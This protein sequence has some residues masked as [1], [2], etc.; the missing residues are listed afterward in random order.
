MIAREGMVPLLAAILVA[1]LVM[2]F[3]GTVPSL[4]FW[5]LAV[6][7]L[8][9]FMDPERDIPSRPMAVLSPADGKIVT[10]SRG[11]HDPYLLR[12]SIFVSV[13]MS[14][15]GV[16]TMRSPIEGKVLEP[17]NFPDDASKPISKLAREFATPSLKVL[18][19]GSMPVFQ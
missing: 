14:P 19:V 1:V 8:V 7:V 16:F 9:L 17:P 13:Q 12:Q 4:F 6:V 3:M 15:Y 18:V 11:A 5:M 2:R 10:V